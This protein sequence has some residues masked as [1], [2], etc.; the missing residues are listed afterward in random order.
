MSTFLTGQSS[1][2]PY[3]WQ[4]QD[5]LLNGKTCLVRTARQHDL[6]TLATVLTEC[7]HPPIG[8]S[9]WMSPV[10][11]LGIYEDLR[12]RFYANEPHAV[13]LVAV[14]AARGE[15]DGKRSL[16]DGAIAGTVELSLRYPK[17]WSTQHQRYLYVSNLAVQP[18][19]RRQGVAKRLLQVCEQIALDWGYADLYLHVLGNNESARNLYRRVGFTAKSTD[20]SVSAFLFRRP[21]QVLMHKSLQRSPASD[22]PETSGA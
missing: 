6:S 3:A 13:C 2:Q 16:A 17:F 7:F 15:T 5:C 20:F 8:I 1:P 10:F 9:A 11:R 19:Y 12:H 21:Q 22:T 14:D 4:S 18:D